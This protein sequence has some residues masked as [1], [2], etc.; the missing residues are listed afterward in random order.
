[1]IIINF[2]TYRQATGSRAQD[3]ARACE[4]AAEETEVDVVVAPQPQDI[5]RLQQRSVRV[6]AQHIDPVE[7]GSHTGHVLA[8]GVADAGATGTVLNHSERRLDEDDLERAIERAKQNG[9]ETVVCA[10][11][12]DECERYSRFDPDFI[13]YEPPELIGG[14]TSVS[15]AKPELIHEAVERSSVPALTGAGIHSR[16]DVEKSIELGTHGVLVASAV[17]K[18]DDPYRAVKELCEG[19]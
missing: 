15:E 16:E 11:N 3:I 10:Q 12:P 19:I 6:Y 18:S 2:K 4:K 8:E 13:A 9:L 17:V 7:P 1:M 14:D 5:G